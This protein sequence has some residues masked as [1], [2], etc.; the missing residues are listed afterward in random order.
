MKEQAAAGLDPWDQLF[1]GGR[2]TSGDQEPIGC[3]VEEDRLLRH[4]AESKPQAAKVVPIGFAPAKDGGRPRRLAVIEEHE[5]DRV[6]RPRRGRLRGEFLD[7]QE[8][9]MHDA[10]L[11]HVLQQQRRVVDP[12]SRARHHEGFEPAARRPGR[13]LGGNEV[14]APPEL[15]PAP[16]ISQV[17]PQESPAGLLV[18][19]ERHG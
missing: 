5:H 6:E 11:A 18:E 17:P 4:V 14:I 15:Q 10:A 3:A 13:L 19:V 16:F 7:G 8:L 9:A 2:V 12:C 1:G